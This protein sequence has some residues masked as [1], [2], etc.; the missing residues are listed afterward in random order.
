MEVVSVLYYYQELVIILLL[1]LAVMW[2]LF[3]DTSV[4]S[5]LLEK[6]VYNT[7]SLYNQLEFCMTCYTLAL[8]VAITSITKTCSAKRSRPHDKAITNIPKRSKTDKVVVNKRFV[9]ILV[10]YNMYMCLI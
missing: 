10:I 5:I 1:T 8:H 4:L 3:C 6:V 9:Y 2:M 7:C